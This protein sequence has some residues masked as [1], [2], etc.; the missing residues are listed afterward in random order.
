MNTNRG[1][2]SVYADDV[3]GIEVVCDVFIP[4]LRGR[5]RGPASWIGSGQTSSK[6][7]AGDGR[8]IHRKRKDKYWRVVKVVSSG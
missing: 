2:S 6:P 7:A 3:V 4:T 8:E 1:A 5:G